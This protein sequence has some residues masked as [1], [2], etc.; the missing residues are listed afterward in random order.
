MAPLDKQQALLQGVVLQDG[1]AP[2]VPRVAP[3]PET[4][5]VTYTLAPGAGLL[6]DTASRAVKVT[7]SRSLATLSFAPVPDAELYVE[8]TGVRFTVAPYMYLG[9]RAAGPMK[10]QRF[11]APT[12]GYFWGGDTL[13]VNLGY[14]PKGTTSAQV[15]FVDRD[16][17]R[18]SAL[19]VIAVPMARYPQ[20]IGKL[21]A[22]GMSD[23][24]VGA[25]A[26]S[27]TVTSNGAGLLFLSI[28]YSTGWTASV[29]GVPTQ[30][31]RANVGFSGVPVEGGTHFV[32][33]HYATPG[34]RVGTIVSVLALVLALALAVFTER[35]LASLARGGPQPPDRVERT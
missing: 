8:I 18:Y 24:A 6:W 21:A 14:Y 13:L 3:A 15:M 23:V 19:R 35:R 22:E 10:L 34:L 7:R 27:G 33:L 29:D 9:A 30:I 26:L 20:R 32:E 31:V 5:E 17:I 25:D 28:P 4:V 2:G 1:A 16:T 12:D 11:I